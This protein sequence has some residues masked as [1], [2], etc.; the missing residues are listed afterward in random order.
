LQSFIPNVNLGLL[1]AAG[2]KVVVGIGGGISGYVMPVLFGS[3]RVLR[4]NLYDNDETSYPGYEA[5][6]IVA[7]NDPDAADAQAVLKNFGI[8][9]NS[10]ENGVFLPATAATENVTGSVIHRGATRTDEYIDYVNDQLGNAVTREEALEI[11]QSIKNDLIAG[12]MPWLGSGEDEE[13]P[14]GELW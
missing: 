10:A 8:D 9:I 14:P 1:F 6:H 5:H 13:V 11:L 4:N 7:E 3:S 2:I 12:R